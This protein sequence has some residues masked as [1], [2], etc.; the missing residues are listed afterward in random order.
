MKVRYTYQFSNGDQLRIFKIVANPN[1]EVDG[2]V[3]YSINKGV[4]HHRYL[5][6]SSGDQF[7]FIHKR[8]RIWM[9]DLVK[10]TERDGK[11]GM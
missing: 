7:Y 10:A 11:G 8:Q 4:M 6:R 1:E 2:I 5:Y 3:F 9:D